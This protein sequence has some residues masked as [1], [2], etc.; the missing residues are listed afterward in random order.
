MWKEIR[1]RQQILELMASVLQVPIEKITE[2]TK[3]EDLEEWDSLM[4]VML[5]AL[6]SFLVEHVNLDRGKC[7]DFGIAMIQL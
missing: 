3:M 4:N 5:I 1:M 2:D 6:F 7:Q